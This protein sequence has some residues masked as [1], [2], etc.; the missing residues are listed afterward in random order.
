MVLGSPGRA[1]RMRVLLDGRPIPAALAGSD[2]HHG[3][4]AVS[5]QRLYDLV[6]L[7]SVQPHTLRLV[8]EKGVTGYSFTFG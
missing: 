3:S 1:R 6:D 7:P 5:F 4:V 8:P 2:V